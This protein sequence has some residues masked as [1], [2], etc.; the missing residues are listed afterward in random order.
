MVHIFHLSLCALVKKGLIAGPLSAID[1]SSSLSDGS[2]VQVAY[3]VGLTHFTTSSE[4]YTCMII[5]LASCSRF[6]MHIV[7][8]LHLK[9]TQM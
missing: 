3:Q 7:R 6:Q 5:F 9:H 4:C 2:K 8:L 1:F